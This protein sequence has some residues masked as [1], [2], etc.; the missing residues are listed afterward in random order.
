MTESPLQSARA[1]ISRIGGWDLVQAASLFAAAGFAINGARILNN[2]PH[3]QDLLLDNFDSA[4]LW[5]GL[6]LLALLVAAWPPARVRLGVIRRDVTKIWGDHYVEALLFFGII[7][8][9]VFMR[10][11]HFG[12]T[13]PPEIGLCCEEPINGGVAFDALNGDRPLDFPL[14]RWTSALGFLTFGETTMGLRFFFPVMGLATLIVFYFLLRQL[15]SVQSALFG[16]ALY[17]VAWWPALRNRQTTGGTLYAVLFAFLI[18]RGMKTKNPLLFLAAGVVAGLMSYEYE[19]FR[20]IP[21]ITAGVLVFAAAR[22]VLAGGRLD[23]SRERAIQL[24]RTFWRPA[25]VFSAAAGIV[26]IPMVV[27]IHHGKDL[28]LTNVHRNEITRGGSRLADEWPDQLR[29]ASTMFLPFGFADYPTSPP[30]DIQDTQLL[31]PLAAS[32]AVAGMAA[33]VAFLWRGY[34]FWFFV[35]VTA[36][37]GGGSLL[38]GEFAPWS[39]F[40]LVPVMLVLAAYLVDDVQSFLSR[41]GSAATRT[42]TLVLVVAAAF[43]LWWNADTLFNDVES[44]GEVQRVYG[45]EF[46]FMYTMCDYLQGR[47]E[48]NFTFAYSN[49]I[50]VDGFAAPRDTAEQERRA[51]S[52]FIWV[53]HDLEGAALP[54]AQEAWPLREVPNGPITLVFAD[55]L[56]SVDDLIAELNVAY[57]GLGEPDRR[58][59]GPAETYQFLAYELDSAADLDIQGLWGVYT[60]VD[61]AEIGASQVDLLSDF[62]LASAPLDPPYDVRWTGLVF[63]DEPIAAVLE[64]ATDA[65]NEVLLDGQLQNSLAAREL[66]PGWHPVEISL[67]VEEQFAMD[68]LRWVDET[69]TASAIASTDT[70]PLGVVNGWLHTRSMGLSGNLRE[71]VTQRLDFSPHLALT[72]VLRL[73][74]PT[75]ELFV[76]EERWEGAFE[77]EEADTFSLRTE[78]R[79]GTVTILVDGTPVITDVAGARLTTKLET[80][81]RLEAGRHTIELVQELARETTWSGATLSI[82]DADGI[83]PIIRPY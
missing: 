29:W 79:A 26:L 34:R 52:D 21:I 56:G 3:S 17:A 25:L 28:Y 45:G 44:S 57:P 32:L 77:L 40:G 66:L 73:A 54:A 6:A 4:A 67:R 72:S 71:T 18:V 37:L 14:V 22:A 42:L 23:Q 43:S 7:G 15:V 46:S 68:G 38:L 24:V 64:L 27:G 8:V 74:S 58:I 81:V 63:V 36:I 16:L 62:S 59:T 78:F 53:C 61:G 48:D 65:P 76:T 2:S 13:L 5:L 11:F 39:F 10:F 31:D 69:G 19:A 49:A 33:A 47:S 82:T 41:F 9:A 35:W 1:V 12:D 55:P 83:S 50:R 60:S 20:V 51:W 30:R 70:F 80:A 75:G